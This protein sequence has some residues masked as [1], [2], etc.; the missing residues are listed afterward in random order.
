[1]AAT[2]QRSDQQ[3]AGMERKRTTTGDELEDENKR[4]KQGG[5]GSGNYSQAEGGR[6]SAVCGS[7]RAVYCRKLGCALLYIIERTLRGH[8]AFDC[9]RAGPGLVAQAVSHRSEWAPKST[10]HPVTDMVTVTFRY[11]A[12][13]SGGIL[14][15]SPRILAHYCMFH[16]RNSSC[17]CSDPVASSLWQNTLA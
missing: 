5:D 10:Q 8:H 12:A 9:K 16:T 2:A 13:L 4:H 17:N 1:M 15:T 6:N 7:G 14:G 3:G 11:K